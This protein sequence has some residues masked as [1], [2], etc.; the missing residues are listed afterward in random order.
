MF[1]G[2]L[3]SCLVAVHW[4]GIK[5]PQPSNAAYG[6]L[7]YSPDGRYLAAASWD[8]SVRVWRVTEP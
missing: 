3:S 5:C 6:G 7:A 4:T 1:F 8:R 2:N